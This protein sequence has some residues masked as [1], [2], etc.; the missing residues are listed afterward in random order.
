MIYTKETF[1][2]LSER[3]AVEKR[4]A[5]PLLCSR[6]NCRNVAEFCCDRCS[7]WDSYCSKKCQE[8]DFFVHRQFCS[9]HLPRE[10]LPPKD[11]VIPLLTS[12]KIFGDIGTVDIVGSVH[13]PELCKEVR[14]PCKIFRLFSH[15][16]QFTEQQFPI[17]IDAVVA[18]AVTVFLTLVCVELLPIL[19]DTRFMV[20]HCRRL[21]IL[22]QK[23]E[24][25][26]ENGAKPNK[27]DRRKL[28][29]TRNFGLLTFFKA[30]RNAS[31]PSEPKT[32]DDL[33]IP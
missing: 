13:G 30:S 5:A 9:K 25:P 32:T 19:C 7:G 22:L 29:P 4:N 16:L 26:D 28:A 20:D 12:F 1:A 33:V 24:D 21:V 14:C 10:K 3:H 11:V 17:L 31:Y 23:T 15:C 27:G 6:S 18:N 2:I 8:E